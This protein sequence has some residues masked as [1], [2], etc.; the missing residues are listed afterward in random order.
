MTRIFLVPAESATILDTWYVLGLRGT[1][2]HDFTLADVFVPE[3]RSVA[4]TDRQERKP[5]LRSTPP[6]ILDMDGNS[7]QRHGYRARAPID[8][9]TELRVQEIHDDVHGVVRDRPLV[10]ARGGGAEAILSAVRAYVQAA[11]GI[12]GRVHVR[13]RMTS[14]QPSVQARLAITHGMHEA[15]PHR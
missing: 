5:A 15:V 6:S 2:S 11:V 3:T 8:A 13:A 10:Q 4:T 7:R 1:G 14:T 9:F 12:Y